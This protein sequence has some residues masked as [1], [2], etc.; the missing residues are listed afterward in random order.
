MYRPPA[1]GAHSW[2][3][4]DSVAYA[5]VASSSGHNHCSLF[6]VA[7]HTAVEDLIRNYYS[8]ATLRPGLAED[9]PLALLATLCKSLV[10]LD[11]VLAESLVAPSLERVQGYRTHSSGDTH[12]QGWAN[13]L[14]SAYRIAVAFA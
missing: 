7:C 5:A 13:T 2:A 8:L 9:K 1:A 12:A 14:A 11:D 10:G 4:H 6:G 3:D